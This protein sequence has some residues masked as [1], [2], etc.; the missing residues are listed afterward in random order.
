MDEVIVL[1]DD[2]NGTE[3]FYPEANYGD[4]R[5]EEKE[6]EFLTSE[7]EA[8]GNS[9]GL[10]DDDFQDPGDSHFAGLRGGL[11]SPQPVSRGDATSRRHLNQP[12]TD[13]ASD[14]DSDRFRRPHALETAHRTVI[15][16]DDGQGIRTTPSRNNPSRR[17]AGHPRYS[18]PGQPRFPDVEPTEDQV[19]RYAGHVSLM[20][21]DVRSVLIKV[22]GLPAQGP[23]VD[24][25][26]A[27]QPAGL[28]PLD[29]DARDAG[30]LR[31]GAS[32]FET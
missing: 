8:E 17:M 23:Y 30:A 14:H 25:K 1:S 31:R 16:K 11:W 20:R 6:D 24:E 13:N 3:A 32:Q 22:P 19:C 4:G 18:R 9:T 15:P 26:L 21:I 12:R 27:T 5:E 2:S 29:P 28:A 10:D 7:G